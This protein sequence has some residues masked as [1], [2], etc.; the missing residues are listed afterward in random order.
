MRIV[1]RSKLLPYL[2]CIVL[3]KSY[4][5]AY[6]APSFHVDI[7]ETHYI[8]LLQRSTFCSCWNTNGITLNNT[9]ISRRKLLLYGFCIM[10]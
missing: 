7:M 6:D 5:G 2:F 9:Y 8:K 4:T 3:P 1:R 10:L